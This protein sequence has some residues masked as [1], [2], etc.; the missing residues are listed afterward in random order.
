MV[1]EKGRV[2]DGCLDAKNKAEL[3][4]HLDGHRSHVM[5]DAGSFDTSTEVVA[6]F[7]LVMAGE[8]TS[9]ECGY[10]VWFYGMDGR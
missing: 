9:E 3:V 1:L 5:L 6:Q 7:I 4:I 8:F 10:L 2:V